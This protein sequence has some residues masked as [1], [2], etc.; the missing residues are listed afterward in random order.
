MNLAIGSNTQYSYPNVL[1]TSSISPVPDVEN[2]AQSDLGTV[3][4]NYSPAVIIDLS[5]AANALI[6]QDMT[7]ANLAADPPTAGQPASEPRPIG[8]DVD[9]DVTL[10]RRVIL[11]GRELTPEE[12]DYFDGVGGFKA[13]DHSPAANE[14]RMRYESWRKS[15]VSVETTIETTYEVEVIG[16]L[17]SIKLGV[18]GPVVDAFESIANAIGNIA[19]AIASAIG[20]LGS[21]LGNGASGFVSFI[22]KLFKR[23]FGA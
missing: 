19:D 7:V 11:N 4:S 8:V 9:V 12:L 2:N 15:H 17:P 22:E 5:A 10:E 23:F 21:A 20:A 3:N 16:D 1:G 14:A 18:S 13:S 6:S